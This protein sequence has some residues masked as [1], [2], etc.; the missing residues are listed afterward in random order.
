MPIE[1]ARGNTEIN[2][3]I[4]ENPVIDVTIIEDG[5]VNI[6]VS[7]IYGTAG[8][9]QYY[10]GQYVVEPDWDQQVLET[11]NLLMSDDVTVEGI[12]VAK[13]DNSAGGKTVYIGGEIIE[14]G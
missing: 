9:H 13:V 3:E 14:N 7:S 6:D 1:I 11:K 8:G 12:Y 4:A 5:H 10:R 2:V